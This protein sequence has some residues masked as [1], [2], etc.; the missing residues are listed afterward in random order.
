LAKEFVLDILNTAWIVLRE[1]FW[2]AVIPALKITI[3]IAIIFALHATW[4][5]YHAEKIEAKEKLEQMYRD[6]VT[7][8]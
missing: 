6:N 8:A 3:P 4:K 7:S 1:I 2:P 5:A